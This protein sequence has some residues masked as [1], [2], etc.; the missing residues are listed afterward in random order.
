MKRVQFCACGCGELVES[1]GSKFVKGHHVYVPGRKNTEETKQRMS[2]SA[3]NRKP[4]VDRLCACGCG[5]YVKKYR[6]Y[7]TGHNRRGVE[8]LWT[9]EHRESH[10][11]AMQ[12]RKFSDEGKKR[13]SEAMKR[14]YSDPEYKSKIWKK[15]RATQGE[16]PNQ[17]EKQLLDLLDQLYPGEW[18]YT[19]DWSFKVGR[20]NPDFVH[21]NGRNLLIELF[22]EYWHRGEDPRYRISYLGSYGY[23]TLVIWTKE[24]DDI[25]LLSGKICNF[26]N[27]NDVSH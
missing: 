23:K 7:I 20:K 19:G 3:L 9:E 6:K 12:G 14:H 21:Q 1:E 11:K 16:R 5:E 25:A 18:K 26:I 13:L 27:E 22:G 10:Q 8:Y 2:E 17:Y 4:W 24:L 15:I